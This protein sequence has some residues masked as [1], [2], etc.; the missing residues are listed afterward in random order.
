MLIF[1]P[2]RVFDY[3]SKEMIIDKSY[4]KNKKNSLLNDG[5]DDVGI[6]E[7]GQLVRHPAQ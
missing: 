7:L 3:I 5:L 6:V 1:H 2:I 4:L